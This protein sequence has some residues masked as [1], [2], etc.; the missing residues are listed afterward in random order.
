MFLK[1][2][3]TLLT[4][5]TFTLNA[6]AD[7]LAALTLDQAISATEYLENQEAVILWCACCEGDAMRAVRITEVY[8]SEWGTDENGEKLY[9]VYINGIDQDGN[10][11]AGEGLDL[12]Y[13]HVVIDNMAYCLGTQLGMPCDPCVE[14]FSLE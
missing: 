1:T 10:E 8:Y 2:F 3:F 14:P 11:V 9:T 4:A 6:K 13:V 5:L 7:Q 12:A